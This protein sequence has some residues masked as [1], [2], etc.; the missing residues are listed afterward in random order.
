MCCFRL[1]IFVTRFQNF[2]IDIRPLLMHFISMSNMSLNKSTTFCKVVLEIKYS[3]S[4][5]V[6]RCM[7]EGLQLKI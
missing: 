4:A 2:I 3:P 7:H 1:K 6:Q 5:H